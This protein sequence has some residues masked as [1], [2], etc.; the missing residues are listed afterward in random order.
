MIKIRLQAQASEHG[1]SRVHVPG[2]EIRGGYS[3]VVVPGC[4]LVKSVS[5]RQHERN[6]EKNRRVR[7]QYFISLA[8]AENL[9]PCYHM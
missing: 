3:N 9:P 5:E 6:L 4:F 8:D 2:T 7:R 1:G